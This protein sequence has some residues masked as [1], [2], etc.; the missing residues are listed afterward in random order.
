[1]KVILPTN[2]LSPVY[3]VKRQTQW[4]LGKSSVGEEGEFVFDTYGK[5][6]P[7]TSAKQLILVL[8]KGAKV[9]DGL[10]LILMDN[11]H[12]KFGGVCIFS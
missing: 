8:R 9:S 7:L 6:T 3:K 1:M 4:A 12:S 10:K 5:A 2:A 11:D